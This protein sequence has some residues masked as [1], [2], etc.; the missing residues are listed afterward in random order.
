MKRL[1]VVVFFIL[2][3]CGHKSEKVNNKNDAFGEYFY[4]GLE[5]GDNG[6]LEIAI[7]C[8]TKCINL[9][10]NN[11]KRL[12]N[13]YYNLGNILI[14]ADKKIE[15]LDNFKKA[16]E[17]NP[18]FASAYKNMGVLKEQLGMPFCYDFRKCCELGHK[19]CCIYF[20]NDC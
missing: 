5:A 20:E 12:S 9:K 17:L 2:V 14:E 15:A 3:G 4:K 7:D 8:F 19:G 10:L 11:K 16:I 1:L 13:A 6:E 18:H